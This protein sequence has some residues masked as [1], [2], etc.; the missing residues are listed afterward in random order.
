M[1]RNDAGWNKSKQ[2]DNPNHSLSSSFATLFQV[3]LPLRS[4]SFPSQQCS[5]D[6]YLMD[7]KNRYTVMLI[8]VARIMCSSS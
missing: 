5:T 1:R 3:N 2:A 8:V 7:V 4:S 6:L